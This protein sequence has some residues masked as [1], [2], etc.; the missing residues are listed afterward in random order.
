MSQVRGCPFFHKLHM[1][2]V[3]FEVIGCFWKGSG[4]A[5][6]T[7]GALD[8]AQG[9][10]HWTGRNQC[11]RGASRVPSHAVCFRLSFWKGVVAWVCFLAGHQNEVPEAQDFPDRLDRRHF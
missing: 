8:D 9:R 5:N 10:F 7:E 2:V 4:V 11:R 1:L 6:L 3:E